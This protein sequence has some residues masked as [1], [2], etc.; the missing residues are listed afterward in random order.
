MS[1][2]AGFSDFDIICIILDVRLRKPAEFQYA[3]HIAAV[4]AD[5]IPG[6]NPLLLSGGKGFQFSKVIQDQAVRLHGLFVEFP[7]LLFS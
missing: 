5:I 1:L 2:F 3:W 7:Y 6:Q 4:K